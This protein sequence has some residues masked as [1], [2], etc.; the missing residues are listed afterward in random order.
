MG[1][2]DLRSQQKA[3]SG[4]ALV[5]HLKSFKL[6]PKFS[7]GVWYFAPCTIRFHESYWKNMTIEE[8]LDVA[9]DMAKFGLR[10]IEAHYPNEVNEENIWLYKRLEKETGVRLI[11]IIPNLFWEADFEF[12]SL[13]NPVAKHRRK[14]IDRLVATLKMNREHKT[15]FSVVWPGGDGYEI[16]FGINFDAMWSRFEDAL[17][18][19]MDE[20]PGVRIA[21]EPKPYEPRGNNIWRNTADGVIMCADV[22]AKLK[23][24]ANKKLLA[25]GHKLV[26]MN[27]ELGHV[28]MGCE[29][30]PYSLARILRQGRLAHTHWNNQP[31]GNYDQD[32]NVGALNPDTAFAGLYAMKMH[33]YSGYY[34]ID[35][36][37]ERIPIRQALQNNFDRMK[38]L[39]QMC[40]DVNHE[41]VAACVENPD[42]NG[43]TGV[44]EAYLTRLWH[45]KAKGLSSMPKVRRG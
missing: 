20:V 44:L 42:L 28:L 34:G 37:P 9:A 2:V 15:D 19:A 41:L 21:I 22:E 17:A 33:G 1:L 11:T 13:S 4:D 31:L 40:D 27:P 5:K 6:E 18:E 32:L 25:A 45:P 14:A 12:G 38:A 3:R 36:F 30:F 39:M 29:D 23:N 24:P 16:S 7:A 10:G 8:R 43:G 26:T 35:I